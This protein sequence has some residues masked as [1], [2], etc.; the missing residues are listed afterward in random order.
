MIYKLNTINI[1]NFRKF[2]NLNPIE[3]GNRITI[4]SGQ[5]GLGKSSILSLIAA[6][7]GTTDKRT[8][9]Q[10]FQPDFDDYFSI[11][12]NESY[13]NY[14]FVLNYTY[15]NGFINFPI[16][17]RESF[18]NYKASGRGIRPI[19]RNVKMPIFIKQGV[20]N[21]FI[22][23]E[24]GLGPA[25]RIPLPTIFSS[26]SRIMPPTEAD[27]TVTK[28]DAKNKFNDYGIL[29][30]YVKWFEEV[31]P[32]SFD[33][34]SSLENANK[35]SINKKRVFVQPQKSTFKTQSI[36]QES[37][38]N[39]ISS[40]VDFY[41]LKQSNPQNY[42][43]GILCIDEFDTTLHPDAQK[44]LLQ[45]L[46][47]LSSPDYLDLQIFLTS[48]SLVILEDILQSQKRN[49][50]DYKLIYFKDI[51]NPY[52]TKINSLIALKAD[53]FNLIKVPAP[54]VKIYCED[55]I[56]AKFLTVLIN[57][58][59][60]NGI[61]FNLPT[62]KI[63]PINLGNQD[64]MALPE[65]DSYFY[66]VVIV[67][68]GDSN[69]RDKSLKLEDYLKNKNIFNNYNKYSNVNFKSDNIIAFPS[70]LPPEA[71]AYRLIDEYINNYEDHIAFWRSL[72]NNP[73]TE[74][75]DTHKVRSRYLVSNV[76]YSKDVHKKKKYVDFLQ[77]TKILSDY[78]I[79]NTAELTKW[80][81]N[82]ELIMNNTLKKLKSTNY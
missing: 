50:N 47:K 81:K 57:A 12:E 60:E 17:K 53:L 74:L 39:I 36:G 75:L 72:E 19:P 49:S 18:N 24:I 9:N 21:G 71:E 16:S 27:S 23:S 70:F 69:I 48:H 67:L 4:F 54:D 20:S 34:N 66:K 45:L 76:N 37:L 61:Q 31:I 43:G 55:D 10:N 64:L 5:N 46:E 41:Y 6:T 1:K 7:S 15:N 62:Y 26:L 59:R 30:T 2:K 42:H 38:G 14:D 52:P 68:D 78:Y 63:I 22:K 79:R 73:D 51:D 56:A 77:E 32:L 13:K 82:L 80:I 3:V 8:N 35:R 28:F 40:L 58:A 11:D 25:A 44:R 29:D 65:K 33:K